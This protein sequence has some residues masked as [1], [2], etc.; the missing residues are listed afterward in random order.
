VVEDYFGSTGNRN[1]AGSKRDQWDAMVEYTRKNG[2][3][4]LAFPTL[5]AGKKNEHSA[6][7]QKVVKKAAKAKV[8]VCTVSAQ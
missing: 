7:Q 6:L 5:F 8:I 4:T 3:R 2:T 1:R